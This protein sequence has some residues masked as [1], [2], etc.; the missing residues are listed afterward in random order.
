[1]SVPGHAPMSLELYLLGPGVGESVV[2]VMPD[3]RVVVVDCCM[4][5][6]TNLPA[7]LLVDLGFSKIDLLVVTHPD[8]DHVAGVEHLVKKFNPGRVWRYPFGLLREVLQVMGGLTTRPGHQRYAAALK[9]QDAI[10]EHLA[11]TGASES[12]EAGRQWAPPGAAYKISTLAPTPYDAARARKRLEGLVDTTSGRPKLTAAAADS[13]TVP[14]YA[15][16]DR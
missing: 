1:M 4:K 15:T 10:D 9:A 16:V 6:G 3:K 2:L 5:D 11:R 12:V 7:E 14:D 8:L 13:F